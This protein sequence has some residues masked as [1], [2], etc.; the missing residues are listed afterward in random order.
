MRNMK[1]ATSALRKIL[2]LAT[3]LSVLSLSVM[4]YNVERI[5]NNQKES[6]EE[7]GNEDND[8]IALHGLMIFISSL[9]FFVNLLLCQGA[10]DLASIELYFWPNPEI[11]RVW[12]IIVYIPLVLVYTYGM[13]S[14]FFLAF[15]ESKSG[16]T[17]VN[18]MDN[19]M[20]W[21]F[22]YLGGDIIM[23]ISLYFIPKWYSTL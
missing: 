10:L 14:C 20:V 8:K 11:I 1:C 15:T 2:A 21:G 12:W 16:N 3:I 19:K 22:V 18:E 13:S 9:T 17:F 5:I 6:K 23:M 7:I 4:V